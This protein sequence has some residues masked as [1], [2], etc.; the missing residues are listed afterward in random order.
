MG[1][2]RTQNT[3]NPFSVMMVVIRTIS[4]DDITA[5]TNPCDPHN[6]HKLLDTSTP[7]SPFSIKHGAKTM[8][9]SPGKESIVND[10]LNTSEGSS[11]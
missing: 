4:R 11:V 3:E 5:T 6:T 9:R 10:E 7:S 8:A 1:L 2:F